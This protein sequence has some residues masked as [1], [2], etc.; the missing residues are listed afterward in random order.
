[1]PQVPSNPFARLS[2][3]KDKKMLGTVEITPEGNIFQGQDPDERVYIKA[4]AHPF[5]NFGWIT[6]LAFLSLLPPIAFFVMINLP[7]VWRFDIRDYISTY[8]LLL[9]VGIY[10]SLILTSFIINLLNWYYDI[11]LVTNQRIIKIDFS[12]LSRQRISEAKLENIEDV[13]E[14]VIGFLPSIFGYGNVNIRTAGGAT[15][16]EFIFRSV[17]NP[18]WFRDVIM[19]LSRYMREGGE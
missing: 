5:V 4:R 15:K 16:E 6:N 12:V 14:S 13:V 11:Y 10:Y 2:L 9:V 19:E 7:A 1:M 3:D 8:I 17:P 18:G